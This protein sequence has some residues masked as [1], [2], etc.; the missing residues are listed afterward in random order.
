[1]SMVFNADE[2]LAMAAQ[3]ERNGGAFYRR[4]VEI[5]EGAGELLLQ[6]AEQED[7]HLALFQGMREELSATE[8]G[9]TTF[10]PNNEAV[11]Y[12]NAMADSHVFDL[13]ED[14]P[15]DLLKGDESLDDIF[16]MAIQAEKDSIAFFVGL[17]E[18]VP[19]SLG[20]GKVDDLIRE[21]TRHIRWLVERKLS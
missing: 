11:L 17:R 6:I 10:D 12:L 20:R 7:L 4:A 8:A 1:M 5:S 15:K 9:E 14:N 16:T 18:L 2:V 3:I 13:D 21:E 19:E